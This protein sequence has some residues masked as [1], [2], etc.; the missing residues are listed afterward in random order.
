MILR[1]SEILAQ[2]ATGKF[3][4]WIAR[5]YSH[6]RSLIREI[7]AALD[8]DPSQIFVLHHAIRVTKKVT[9]EVTVR[10]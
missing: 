5:N 7:R 2:I 4:A 3:N 8:T 1:R 10:I 9:P 6:G